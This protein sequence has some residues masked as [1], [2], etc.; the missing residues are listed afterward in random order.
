MLCGRSFFFFPHKTSPALSSH[1]GWEHAAGK[2][3]ASWRIS[4]RV[5]VFRGLS[6]R[7]GSANPTEKNPQ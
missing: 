7:R 6:A 4:S 1:M 2:A 3:S 5:L